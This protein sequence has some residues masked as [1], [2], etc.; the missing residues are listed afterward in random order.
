MTATAGAHIIRPG[1]NSKLAPRAELACAKANQQNA[2]STI[3]WARDAEKTVRVLDATAALALGQV[4]T[5]HQWLYRVMTARVAEAQRRITAAS[6]PAHHLLWL[7]IHGTPS[8]GTPV[9][10]EA[11]SWSNADTGGNGH[12]GGLQMHPDWGNGTS[13]YASDDSQLVQ[14]QAAE[15]AYRDSGYAASF[16]SGQWGQTVGP[17][18]RYA[19]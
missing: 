5:N 1:C 18:W 11:A 12:Y 19:G 4:V 8:L 13:Y 16:L 3:L 6:F 17:C 14:E 15:K 10:H 9:G 2:L 7:C